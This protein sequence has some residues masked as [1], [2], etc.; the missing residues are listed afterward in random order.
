VILTG[1]VTESAHA[2]ALLAAGSADL[3]GVGRAVL[4]DPE[5]ARNA[6]RALS[7]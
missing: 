4:K 2:E 1:G 6:V 3:I 5:W 7:A